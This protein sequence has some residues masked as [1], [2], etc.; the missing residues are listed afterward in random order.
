M[1]ERGP[2]LNDRRRKLPRR[3]PARTALATPC[4]DH[5]PTGQGQGLRCRGVRGGGETVEGGK[6]R[7]GETMLEPEKCSGSFFRQRNVRQH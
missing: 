6:V 2:D 4:L 3:V 1:C 5:H 7:L